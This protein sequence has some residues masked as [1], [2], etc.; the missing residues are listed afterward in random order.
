[1]LLSLLL[2]PCSTTIIG[3]SVFLTSTTSWMVMLLSLLPPPCSPPIVYST[4]AASGS[5]GYSFLARL[6][7]TW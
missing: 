5:W 4:I 2:T 3:C 7:G 6:Q 1:M